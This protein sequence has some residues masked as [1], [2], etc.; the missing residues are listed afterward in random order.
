MTEEGGEVTGPWAEAVDEAERVLGEDGDEEWADRQREELDVINNALPDYTVTGGHHSV[1]RPGARI[2][3]SG[4]EEHVE[5]LVT[6]SADHERL[7]E[8][9]PLSLT[10]KSTDNG[11]EEGLTSAELSVEEAEDIHERLGEA[12]EAAKRGDKYYER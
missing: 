10:V 6:V 5:T 9:P 11:M 3:L 7:H 2:S 12:I 1:K 4:E 8:Q